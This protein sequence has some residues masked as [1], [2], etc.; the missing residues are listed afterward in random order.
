[1]KSLK[2]AIDGPAGSGKSSVAREVAL[3]LG[4]Q[5]IDSGALYRSV[6]WFFLQK[7]PVDA[8][9]DFAG[10]LSEC[11][12]KQE[13]LGDGTCRTFVNG[14]DVSQSIRSGDIARHI[15]AV[16]DSVPV[17]NFVNSLLRGFSRAHSVIMDGRDIGTVVFPD[18]ELKI[19][20]DAS[21]DVRASRRVNEYKEMGK[22]V[23]ENIIKKQIILRDEQDKSRP[24]GAL[25]KAEDAL[26]LDTTGMSKKEVV[27]RIKNLIK[28]IL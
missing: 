8:G 1:M 4:L 24:F 11:S 19:Y 25:V 3:D 2:I 26:Y 17:R 7:G 16:S 9:T 6:T 27:D 12:I 18:A 28:Q 13:F 15:G 23:D 14:T 10:G 5:Y 20:L 21:V 22:N